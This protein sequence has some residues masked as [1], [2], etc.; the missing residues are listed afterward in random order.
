MS[1]AQGPEYGELQSAASHVNLT[2]L[3]PVLGNIFSV[4]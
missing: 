3:F 4:T 2:F 1:T